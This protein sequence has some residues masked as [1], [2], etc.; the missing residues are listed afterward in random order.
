MAGAIRNPDTGKIIDLSI[1]TSDLLNIPDV[2]IKL[3]PVNNYGDQHILRSVLA[4]EPKIN[5]VLHFTDP[6]F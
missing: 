6:R 1:A 2:Q 5:G 4:N 3:Y